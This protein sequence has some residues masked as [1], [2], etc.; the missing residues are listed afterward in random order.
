MCK[1]KKSCQHA[2]PS[3]GSCSQ[4]ETADNDNTRS[5]LCWWHRCVC[6]RSLGKTTRGQV[7]VALV[8][9][10][11]CIMDRADSPPSKTCLQLTMG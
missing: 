5:T 1:G 8:H 4:E 3:G 7:P 11:H 6:S 2:S 9:S 10:Q